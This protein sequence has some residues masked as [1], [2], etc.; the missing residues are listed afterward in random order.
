MKEN[1]SFIQEQNYLKQRAL[2][3]DDNILFYPIKDIDNNIYGVIE[4]INK[5]SGILNPEEKNI[6][7]KKNE[8]ILSFISKILGTYLIYYN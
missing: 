2:N 3:K 4:V 5:N 7:D 6:F 1:S 8:I